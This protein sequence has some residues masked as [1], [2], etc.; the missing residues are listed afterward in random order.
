MVFYYTYRSPSTYMLGTSLVGHHS[1]L[2]KNYSSSAE[3]P[4]NLNRKDLTLL[5]N[6]ESATI[7]KP[8]PPT[9]S[10]PFYPLMFYPS[11]H[12]ADIP[13]LALYH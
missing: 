10:V 5:T 13:V 1:F 12:V 11:H 7:A 3:F 2:F 9:Q 4:A 6:N 8:H